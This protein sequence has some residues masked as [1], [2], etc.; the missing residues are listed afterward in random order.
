M[1]RLESVWVTLDWQASARK[2]RERTGCLA[3]ICW[4]AL[5]LHLTLNELS[6]LC[7]DKKNPFGKTHPDSKAEKCLRVFQMNF[8]LLAFGQK[9]PGNLGQLAWHYTRSKFFNAEGSGQDPTSRGGTS[10]SETS[11]TR[12]PGVGG[13]SDSSPKDTIAPSAQDSADM[14]HLA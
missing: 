13:Q 12:L 3:W 8:F 14:R 5:H 10:P 7:L 6:S 4:L 1:R 9:C 2:R 11:A